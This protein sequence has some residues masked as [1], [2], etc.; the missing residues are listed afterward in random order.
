VVV[1]DDGSRGEYSQIT[2]TIDPAALE[3]FSTWI[4]DRFPPP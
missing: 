1:F 4:T 2:T 3:L